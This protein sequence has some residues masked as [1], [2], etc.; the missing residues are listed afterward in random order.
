MTIRRILLLLCLLAMPTL[1]LCAQE[2]R[3]RDSMITSLETLPHDIR[4]LQT[5]Q[6]IVENFQND[7]QQTTHYND[8]LLEEAE[9]QGND[10]Y[11]CEAYLTR[12]IVA[13]NQYDSKSVDQA[14]KLLEPLARKEKRYDLYFKGRRAQLDCM[15]LSQDFEHVER[16]AREMLTEAQGLNNTYGIL[17]ANQC[18]ANIYRMTYRSRQALELLEES[19]PMALDTNI[20]NSVINISQTTLFLHQE[21]SETPEEFEKWKK[22][23]KEF[24]TY[25]LSNNSITRQDPIF[26]ILYS[27]YLNYCTQQ[28]DWAQAEAICQKAEPFYSQTNSPL[29]RIV[30]D[31]NRTLYYNASEQYGKALES[32]RAATDE[33]QK[34]STG[35]DY[36][37]M[38]YQEGII[39]YRLGRYDEALSNF[40]HT[41]AF[42]DSLRIVTIKK[43]YEQIR[44]DFYADQLELGQARSKHTFQIYLLILLG[45][46]LLI[47]AYLMIYLL[48]SNRFLRKA[49]SEMRGMSM[50]MEQ[51]N[52]V[53]DRFLSNISTTIRTPLNT[54]VTGSLRLSAQ[55]VTDPQARAELSTTIRTMSSGLLKI[56]NDIL[57]L[58]RLEA[59][60]MRL[61]IT[62]IDLSLLIL[63]A[64]GAADHVKNKIEV[65]AECLDQTH[66]I[67][68]VDGSRMMQILTSLLDTTAP[69]CD[70]INVTILTNSSNLDIE[71]AG[72]ALAE[73]EPEQQVVIRNEINRMLISRFGGRYELRSEQSPPTVVISLPLTRIN[74]S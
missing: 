62:Q 70:S 44:K 6:S 15:I 60:M 52:Q 43:Q 26:L 69:G 18:L 28:N 49:E 10:S 23:L 24:E 17:E 51:A 72:T 41:Q 57:D 38:L 16:Q 42:N 3:M 12:I 54:V 36:H 22:T 61:D 39:L 48:R 46:G 25:L 58:S 1:T 5:L 11:K 68:N 14:M 47:V 50:R 35:T 59:G 40:K 8:L 45:T 56:I 30:Y 20:T 74:R 66:F 9:L 73:S 63:D 21:L 27:S 67:A 31:R 34:I 13:Y 65:G 71:V 37:E 2:S 33:M 64:V 32:L 53:K 7:I 4:R 29:F 19:L 55:E